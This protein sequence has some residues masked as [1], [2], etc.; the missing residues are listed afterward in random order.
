MK[1]RT[2]NAE[3]DQERLTVLENFIKRWYE[4]TGCGVSIDWVHLN[5]KLEPAINKDR[6]RLFIN[7]LVKTGRVKTTKD[8]HSSLLYYWPSSVDTDV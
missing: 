1:R 2:K 5:T 3:I 6:V 8:K 4:E 7:H